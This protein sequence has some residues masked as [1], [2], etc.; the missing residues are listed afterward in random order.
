[1][2]RRL[3]ADCVEEVVRPALCGDGHKLALR[4]RMVGPFVM[5]D[6]FRAGGLEAAAHPH[7]GLAALTY[8]FE[9]ELVQRDSLGGVQAIGPGDAHLMVA[10]RGIVHAERASAP[11][12]GVQ[13]WVALPRCDEEMAAASRFLAR[14]ALP[15]LEGDGIR[16]R[17]IAGG[18]HGRQAPALC[19][20]ALFQA[21]LALA[22]GARFRLAAEHGERAA[23]VVQGAVEVLGRDGVFTA[24]RLVVFRPGAEVVLRARGA[25]RLMLFGGEKLPEKR[26]ICWNF[27]SS[28]RERIAQAAQDWREGRF[29]PVPGENAFAPLPEP[30]PP[31]R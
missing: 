4:R 20:A 30:W 11:L 19:G 15:S 8:L 22:D 18:L 16:L 3:G 5:L 6:R 7:I 17:L 21:D 10:G 25:A 13:S 14:D 23:Y 24:D 29:A 1:M 28:R 2:T 31:R 26:H 27:V 12:C 9:G